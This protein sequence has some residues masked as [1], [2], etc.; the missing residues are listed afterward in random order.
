MDKWNEIRTAYKL[1]QHQTLSATAQEMGVHRSTVMRHIDTLEAELGVLLFQRN[2]KGYLP[3]EAG[4]EIM[5]LGE[6]TENHF[7]Q[8]GAQIKSKEQALSGTLTVTAI[9]DT[10]SMLMP[11]IQQYQR[12]YPNMR[13]DFIGDLRKFNLEYG[14]ADIAIRSGDKPTTPDNIVFPIASVEMVLCAHKSYIEQ[15]GL[16]QDNNW[17]QHRFIAMKERPQHLLWNEWIYDTV[18]ETQVVFLCSSVQ[19]AARALESGCGIAVMPREFVERDEDLIS[20]SSSLVWPMPVWALVHRDMY[21]LKKIRA[22]IEIL[23][24][25]QQTPT[26]FKI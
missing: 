1:A 10:A 21:N 15:Y 12:C 7:S 19:V 22:F 20:V 11:V 24:G 23:R 14:E 8:L 5:R 9:N 17:Q 6:V 13:V 25:D 16:P 4:L 26:H 2:D 18:P 3:T